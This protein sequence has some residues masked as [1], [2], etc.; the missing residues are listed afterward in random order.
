MSA[1]K[2]DY[3]EVLAVQKTASGDEIKKSFRKEAFKYHPDRNAGDKAA[4]EKFKEI[5]EAYDVLSDDQ[6]RKIYDQYG[7]AGLEG[8]A[9]RPAED[10][11]EQFQDLFADFF[12]PGFGGGGG[13]GGGRGGRDP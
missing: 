2:R 12:G 9:T 3:Y 8:Q 10:I 4:E 11:F 6:K 5:T 13:G 1:A 7:H